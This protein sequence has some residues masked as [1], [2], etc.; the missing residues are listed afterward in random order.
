MTAPG[1]RLGVVAQTA[2]TLSALYSGAGAYLADWNET[3]IHNPSWPPHAKFHNAQTMSLG[4]GLAAAALAVTWAPS[5]AAGGTRLAAAAFL[6]SLYPATQ[7][8]ALLY[9]GTALVDSPA[10]RRG[11]QAVIAAGLVAANAAAVL[12]TLRRR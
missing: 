2:F 10:E 4:A 1:A 6:A 11:P 8:S 9:P 5:R 7:L 12:V 3:H